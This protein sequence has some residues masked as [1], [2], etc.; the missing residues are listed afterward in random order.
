MAIQVECDSCFA[1]YRVKD[2][3]AGMRIRCKE[4][5][6]PVQ[7][8]AGGPA[9]APVRRSATS[10]R[11]TQRNVPASPGMGVWIGAGVGG[12]VLLVGVIV[13]AM[14]LGRSRPEADQQVANAGPMDGAIQAAAPPSVPAQNAGAGNPS[15]DSAVASPSDRAAPPRSW[16]VSADP[17]AAVDAIPAAAPVDIP[18]PASAAMDWAVYPESSNRFVALGSNFRPDDVR[19]VW[20]LHAGT[21]IGTVQ[22]NVGPERG[23]LS[24]DGRHL[25]LTAQ[26]KDKLLVFDVAAGRQVSEMPIPQAQVSPVMRFAGPSRLATVT[27]QKP[28]EVFSIP[29]GRREHSIKVRQFLQPNSLAC[30]PGGKFAALVVK[31]ETVGKNVLTIYDLESGQPAET[32]ALDWDEGKAGNRCDGLAFSPDGSELAAL[33][34]SSG[35]KAKDWLVGWNMR[36]GAVTFEHAFD[37]ELQRNAVSGTNDSPDLRWFPDNK[38]L[39]V[40]GHF[41][42]DKSVGGPLWRIPQDK[43]L[44]ASAT[45]ILTND[46]VLVV[47]GPYKK[48]RVRTVALPHDEIAGSAAAIGSGGLAEDAGLPPLTAANRSAGELISLQDVAPAWSVAPE[49]ATQP[50]F[51]L[52]PEARPVNVPPNSVGSLLVSSA[53][54]GRAVI[55]QDRGSD[56]ATMQVIGLRPDIESATFEVPFGV[57]AL[58]LDP[59]GTQLLTR[60]RASGGRLDI[61]SVPEGAH[62]A[63]WRPFQEAGEKEQQVVAAAFVDA[64]HVLT[65]NSA[66]SLALWQLPS[67]RALYIIENVRQQQVLSPASRAT[68]RMSMASL[69]DFDDQR[70]KPIPATEQVQPVLNPALPAISPDGRYI[71]IV[72]RDRL[73][74][75]ESLTGQVRGAVPARGALGAAAFHPSGKSIAFT[76]KRPAGAAFLAVNLADGTIS[77]EFPLPTAGSWLHWCDDNTLFLDNRH[78]IDLRHERIVWKYQSRDATH[79]PQ[80]P[81]GRHWALVRTSAQSQQMR[82]AGIALPDPQVSKRLEGPVTPQSL[83]LEPGKGVTLQIDLVAKPPTD[84]GLESQIRQHLTEQLTSSGIGV[85]GGQPLTFRVTCTTRQTGVQLQYRAL[86]SIGQPGGEDGTTLAETRVDCKVALQQGSQELWSETA[87]ISSHVFGLTRLKPGE[88]IDAHLTKLQWDAVGEFF[89]HVELPAYAFPEGAANGVGTSVL[90]ARGAEQVGR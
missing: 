57:E 15:P 72:D 58:S 74:L 80:S 39:L 76:L 5:G 78:L 3:R 85:D 82:L 84:T 13:V 21:R 9:P 27:F 40:F 77:S 65:L 69:F 71:A 73:L 60:A 51:G 37:G 55:A 59:E 56:R 11:K 12:V 18:I 7:V 45:G 20:D 54:G 26:A 34:H 53:E 47:T 49:D 24:P 2:D 16:K 70:A 36:T 63:A 6:E 14:S 29:S 86:G 50:D 23:A 41:L 90:S 61:W 52:L 62:V 30:S 46:C 35:L 38:S 79:S 19:E 1:S 17:P 75:L 31:D 8:P 66:G 25:V 42:F 88:S 44:T 68:A 32:L 43:E 4:C 64:A 83:P 22:T 87:S 48:R 81:D 10:A 33:L 89:R 67:C 28:L